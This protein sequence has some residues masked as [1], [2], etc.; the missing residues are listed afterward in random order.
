M[1]P[2]DWLP[3]PEMVVRLLVAFVLGAI[4]GLER[5]RRDRPAGLRTHILVSVAAA[6]LMMLSELVARESFDPGR[7]A[8]AVVTGMGFLGA[9]TIIVHGSAVRGLTT[10]ASLWSASAVG[11]AVGLGWYPAAIVATLLIFI[12]LVAMRSLEPLIA[13]DVATTRVLVNLTPG[14]GLPPDLAESVAEVGGQLRRIEFVSSDTNEGLE[15]ALNIKGSAQMFSQALLES[16]G[17]QEEIR[18]ARI[19]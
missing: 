16:L 3:M 14:C 11:L 15:I 7:I 18:S 2:V 13:P 10:A 1:E 6:L 8:A 19:P 4:I 5:E 9:G 17:R 12:T